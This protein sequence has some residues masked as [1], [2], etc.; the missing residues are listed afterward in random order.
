MQLCVNEN[1]GRIIYSGISNV[2]ANEM[3]GE[4][5]SEQILSYVSENVYFA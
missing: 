2:K 4:H 3:V 5:I 1:Y